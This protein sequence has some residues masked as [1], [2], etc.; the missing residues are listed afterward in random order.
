MPLAP[1][2]T[3]LGKLKEAPA[4][5]RLLSWNKAAVTGAKYDR[6]E[7]SIYIDRPFIREAC[8]ILRDDSTVP[9]NFLSDVTCV[10]WYPSEPR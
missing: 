8:A 5:A 4:L 1:A 10:D 3:D 7:L 2:I 6:E 9:F